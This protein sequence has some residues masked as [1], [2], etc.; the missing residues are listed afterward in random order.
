MKFRIPIELY[1][2]LVVP[3]S[4][5]GPDY[6]GEWGQK[7]K[8][9][10]MILDIRWPHY[11]WNQPW[12]S[13]IGRQEAL[14]TAHSGQSIG[15]LVGLSKGETDYHIGSPNENILLRKAAETLG[16]EEISTGC[17]YCR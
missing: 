6:N 12:T 15:G 2:K 1:D 10:E 11:D 5:W 17:P 3:D 13:G 8:I 16:L 4:L 7:I 9:G 14:V